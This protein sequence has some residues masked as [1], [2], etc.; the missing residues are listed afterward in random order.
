MMLIRTVAPETPPIDLDKA[1]VQVRAPTN[2]DDREEVER[3]LHAA[4]DYA[5]RYT[6]LAFAPATYEARFCNWPCRARYDLGVSPVRDVLSVRYRDEDGVE[7][8]VSATDYEW[9]RTSAGAWV[10]FIL[11]YTFPSLHTDSDYPVVVTFRAGFDSLDA[12]FD[13]PELQS[14]GVADSDGDPGDSLQL[15]AVIPSAVLLLTQ[16]FYDHA[17][18]PELKSCAEAL[19]NVVKVY[20]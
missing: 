20:R 12:D 15:P 7:Q 8:T 16:Y 18:A 19:L 14:D 6:G 10:R 4:I 17:A 13:T 1:S 3:A 9:Q 5:E 11:D 2:D